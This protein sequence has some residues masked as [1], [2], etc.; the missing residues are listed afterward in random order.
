MVPVPLIEKSRFSPLIC[1]TC[2]VK[3]QMSLWH[4]TCTGCNL[5]AFDN[6]YIPSPTRTVLITRAFFK[7]LCLLESVF[8]LALQESPDG[9]RP[10]QFC[11][12][13][14][15]ILPD[16]IKRIKNFKCIGS[17]ERLGENWH[18]AGSPMPWALYIYLFS[19]TVFQWSAAR[20]S[21]Q[22]LEMFL[23]DLFPGSLCF[24]ATINSIFWKILTFTLL[25]LYQK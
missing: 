6:F 11:I 12:N 23:L 20:L 13:V 25:L 14:S 10:L 7:S 5:C 19:K 18:N 4:L 21:T 2:S 9:F 17:I 22:S 3:L 8:Q 16:P 15:F 24:H 1:N